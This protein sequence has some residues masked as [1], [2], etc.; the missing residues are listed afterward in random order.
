MGI[1]VKTP[2]GKEPLNKK[3]TA[4]E[5]KEALG[6]TPA[7]P[8]D[9][10]IPDV[11]IDLSDIESNDDT[12]YIVDKND[13]IVAK[14][15]RDGI[16]TTDVNA[17]G[18]YATDVNLGA[19][20]TTDWSLK[21]HLEDSKLE[22][23]TEDTVHV[24]K[25]DRARWNANTAGTDEGITEIE[26]KI[27]NHIASSTKHWSEADR[28]ILDV[29]D[30]ETFCIV[31][32]YDNKIAEINAEGLHAL[33]V[34]IGKDGQTVK[35]M[36]DEAVADVNVDLSDY[37]TSGQVDTKLEGYAKTG[38]VEAV[39]SIAKGAQQ[40]VSFESYQ[41]MIAEVDT[42][43]TDAYRVG[44]N[45]LIK[46]LSVPD[47]WVYAKSTTYVAYTY[48]TDEDIVT[49]LKTG[50]IKV[51]YYEF[52][53]LETGKV[54][55]TDYV[56]KTEQ[57]TAL[58]NLKQEMSEEIVSDKEEFHIVDNE[59]RIVATIDKNGV[60][61]VAFLDKD[62]NAFTNLTP[63]FTRTKKVVGFASEV[64]TD[65]GYSAVITLDTKCRSVENVKLL[66]T[67]GFNS[68][69]VTI[70][71]Y[72]GR[73]TVTGW[74]DSPIKAVSAKISYTAA[75]ADHASSAETCASTPTIDT[76]IANKKYVDDEIYKFSSGDNTVK[77]AQT[78]KALESGYNVN[79]AYGSTISVYFN[80][81][82][83]Y[84]VCVA[85][86][87]YNYN[88]VFINM[89]GSQ[90]FMLY[91]TDADGGIKCSYSSTAS[92]ISFTKGGESISVGSC[93]VREI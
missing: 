67:N 92:T 50:V 57:T 14:I 12:F 86:Q 32:Q 90:D 43:S 47:L 27:D 48:T 10:N 46:T 81:G 45:V 68:Q 23:A 40:A 58:D 84:V 44:Q 62:G 88:G 71:H 24:T 82:R 13:N 11:D 31:D 76:H 4:S 72:E 77:T 33:N 66:T 41:D 89:G 52:A 69:E 74:V 85:Y 73:I 60:Q 37:Y 22:T 7:N 2:T 39:E 9:I 61:S 64:Q 51:G 1:Y 56:K 42:L 54:D 20:D 38:D 36:I 21:K 19:K 6:Y 70:S 59:D 3:V 8:D 16:H 91:G 83:A 63:M 25:A 35:E 75:H 5:I 93:Y 29:S 34:K 79:K 18:V 15:D 26:T 78:A 49:A 53:A 28:D 80:T 30:D 55:L 17:T 87:M 65:L